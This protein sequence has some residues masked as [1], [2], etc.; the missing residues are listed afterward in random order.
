MSERTTY[1]SEGPKCPC[2]GRQF[3]ADD[4]IYYD[5]QRYTQDECDECGATFDVEVQTSVYWRCTERLANKFPNT[6]GTNA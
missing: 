3:T 5:E 4:G 2:C 1:E 6:G